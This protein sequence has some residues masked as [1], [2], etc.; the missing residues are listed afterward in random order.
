[1]RLWSPPQTSA[2]NS[3]SWYIFDSPRSFPSL[4]FSRPAS[5]LPLSNPLPASRL[6]LPGPPLRRVAT[7]ER[8]RRAL[9]QPR[10]GGAG[11]RAAGALG[12]SGGR[13]AGRQAD[14]VAGG[15]RRPCLVVRAGGSESL[16]VCEGGKERASSPRR[17]P[18]APARPRRRPAAQRRG[19]AEPS[20]V[21]PG[22][23]CSPCTVCGGTSPR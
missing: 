23:C 5:S 13:Q 4:S 7:A 2:I 8:A 9:R 18:A 3:L 22:P 6:P 19:R 16:S 10:C 21:G 14:G 12:G 11:R 20:W 1:M 17:P 15:W